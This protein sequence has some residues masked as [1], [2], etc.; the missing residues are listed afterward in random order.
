MTKDEGRRTDPSSVFRPFASLR[1][2]PSSVLRI[3]VLASGRGTSLQAM[4]DAAAR[5][6]IPAEVAVVLSNRPSAK[7]LARA[8]AVG[9]PALAMP[10]QGFPDLR[11]RDVA[12]ADR[13]REH[14]IDLVVLAGY[15]RVL[16]LDFLAAFPERILNMHPSLLPAFGGKGAMSPKPQA[17]AL[18]YGCKV[19]GCTVHLVVPDVAIDSGPIVAQAAVPV[20]DDDTVETLAGRI[21]RA[22]HKTLLN[23]IRLFAAG[24][25]RLEG[26]RVLTGAVRPVDEPTPPE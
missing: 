15:D 2:G 4:L 18:A 14:Q 24:K 20:Y 16:S 19:A 10:Q 12:M 17:D 13:L 6:E 23:A 7:A 26:R 22:E 1:A 25:I 3:G 21:L 9:V 11:A 8:R 5:G